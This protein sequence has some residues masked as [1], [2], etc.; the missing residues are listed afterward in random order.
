MEAAPVEVRVR[1]QRVEARKVLRAQAREPLDEVVERRV[2]ITVDVRETVERV[3]Y[4]RCAV[5]D[6]AFR[7]GDP[8]L[9]LGADEM[10]DDVPWTPAAFDIGCVR[11]A[12]WQPDQQGTEHLGGPAQQVAVVR[13]E[14]VHGQGSALASASHRPAAAASPPEDARWPDWRVA[15][16]LALWRPAR[17]S[18]QEVDA[19]RAGTALCPSAEQRRDSRET[20]TQEG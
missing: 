7:A 5:L 1:D 4:P 16:R 12:V 13:E 11:P 15:A 2:G 20:V 10:A 9:E 8:V 19:D 6:D 14:A 3:E 18:A 17:T